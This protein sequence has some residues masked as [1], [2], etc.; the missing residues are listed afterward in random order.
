M[1]E[2]FLSQLWYRVEGLT[3][4]LKV[5]VTVH[6]HRYRGEPWYVLHDHAGGRVHRFTPA[7]YM[8][9]GRFDGR[10]SIGEIW[11][12]LAETYDADAPSQDDVIQLL[13]TLH[14]ND[15][16]RYAGTPDVADLLERYRKKSTELV[17]QNLMNPVSIRVPLWDPDRFLSRTLPVVRPLL[18]WWG[19]ALWLVVVCWGGLV[20]AQNYGALT[21]NLTD[22][23]LGA[24]NIAI[25]LISYPLL[26]ALHELAHGYLTKMRGQE[27]RE[28]GIMFLVFFPVPYV[29]ASAAAALRNKW[30]R[31]AVSAGGIFVE[32]FA[33]AL[34][35]ILWAEAEAGFLRAVA[36]NIVMIGGLS[37]LFVNGN[38]LLKF[39]GYYVL[40][41]LIESPNFGTRAN[42]YWGWLIQRRLFGAKQLKEPVAT[43][44]ERRWF[45]VYAPAALVYRLSVMVG[46]ALFVAGKY[47]FAGVVLALWSV[48]NA[49]I[50]PLFKHIR[51]VLISP[52]LRKVR[53]RAKRWTFGSIAT[54]AAALLLIP[55]PLRTDTEGVVW[56]PEAAHLRAGAP[57]F[58]ARVAAGRGAAVAE[59][60]ALVEL[61]APTLAARIEGLRWREEEYRRRLAVLSVSDRPRAEAARLELAEATGEL[62]REMARQGDML[63]TAPLAG[64]FEPVV[65]PDDLTGRFFNEGDLVGYVLPPRP[66][67]LRIAVAQADAALVRERLEGV[68]VRFAGALEQRHRVLLIRAVPQAQA[69]LPSPVLGSRGG[70]RFLTAPGDE[71]GTA[72]LDPVFVYDLAMPPDAPVQPYGMRVLVRFDHGLEPAAFQAWRRVRQLFLERFNA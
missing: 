48:F 31:A 38:P 21:E 27:V 57:G 23:L 1:A 37:T 64:R 59:G 11:T 36:F 69:S 3:P 53:G 14:Q 7:A 13:A 17:K 15:L 28:M 19:L 50:K 62:A 42:L 4:R 35:L 32:T 51:H 71:E 34:A 47:Y 29:D 9:I 63:L 43:P 10:T 58:V 24:R 2:R 41:D 8:V 20:A 40:A 16:I 66:E 60:E 26:K 44:G 5:H 18:G 39:D 61:A 12:S 56:L 30:H 6:R 55:L 54:L 22:R 49:V 25:T 72:S 70:G 45:L 68:E 33:A 65:P 46:I 52:G 67:V